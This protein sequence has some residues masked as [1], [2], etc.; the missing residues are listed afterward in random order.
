MLSTSAGLPPDPERAVA[1]LVRL[2]R[3]GVDQVVLNVPD[4][5][6]AGIREG[7]ER[8]A[9]SILPQVREA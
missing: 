1:R 7:I 8:L 2:K 9:E 4:N 3:A 6:A 5:T